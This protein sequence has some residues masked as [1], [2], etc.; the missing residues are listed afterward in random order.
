MGWFT[1][2]P[3]GLITL[4]CDFNHDRFDLPVIP[5]ASASGPAGAAMTAAADARNT[6][7]LPAPLADIRR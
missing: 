7:H 2:Q 6:R 1:S 5:P 3:A 4:I